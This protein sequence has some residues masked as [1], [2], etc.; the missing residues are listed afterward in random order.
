MNSRDRINC[1]I[2]HKQPDILPVDFGGSTTTGIHVC[3]VYKLRQYYGLDK[4]NTPVKIIEPFQMLGEIKDDLKEVIGI[5]VTSL[6]WR[7]NFLGF[8][9]EN[10]KEWEFHGVPVLV[11]SKFNTE[12]SSDESIYQYP[13]GDKD[14]LPSAK[15]PETGY[16]IDA[17]ERKELITEGDLKVE[18]NLE[19]YKLISEEDLKALG[20]DA[21][22]L[23]INTDYS[24]LGQ[25]GS[26]G[27]GDIFFIPGV[28]I[29]NPKGIRSV[30]EWY[31]SL[32]SRKDYVKKLFKGQLEVALE[33]YKSIAKAVGNKIDIMFVSG[34][35]FGT[36]ENLFI[37]L[38][39]YRELFKPFHTKVNNWIHQNTNWK[40]FIHTCGAIYRLIPDLIEAGFDIL[41]PIQISAR[42]MDPVKLKKSFGKNI[43]FWG[44]GVD[45]Q[46]TLPLG[47]SKQVKEETKRLIEIF[48][49]DGGFVFNAVHNIQGN[50]PIE[51][52]VAMIEAIQEYRK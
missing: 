26:S 38:D 18:Y 4:P 10:W 3:I 48:S 35:D 52:I 20:E 21:D 22:K 12:K 23:Y 29:K 34:T 16:F 9:N 11:P 7:T 51:N 13:E 31:I 37:S 33:N 27:F 41:N 17:I 8:K 6:T 44:G 15:L 50:V 46:R 42:D 40:C 30:E 39:L 24:I 2:N 43:T 19:E 45:T 25:I 1:V 28:Q 5:D 36:Q 14:T 32:L 47:T 49:S